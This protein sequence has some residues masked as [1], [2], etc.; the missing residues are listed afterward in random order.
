MNV[1][2]IF[3]GKSCEHD[4]SVITASQIMPFVKADRVLAIYVDRQGKIQKCE[5]IK[6]LCIL[7][8]ATICF[9]D[10]CADTVKSMWQYAACTV[11]TERTVSFL[12]FSTP[13]G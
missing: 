8:L 7:N 13:V 2:V 6:S 11:L 12:Q 3:G 1:A 5:K 9:V 10:A 4:V